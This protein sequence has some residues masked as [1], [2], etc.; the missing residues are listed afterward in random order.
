[1]KTNFKHQTP[2]QKTYYNMLKTF[3]SEVNNY[4]ID[5]LNREWIEKSKSSYA[6]PIAAV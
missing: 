1:M 2:V 3:Y 4:I 6:S 5:L